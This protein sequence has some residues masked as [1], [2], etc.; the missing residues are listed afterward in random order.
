MTALDWY[1]VTLAGVATALYLERCRQ[2]KVYRDKYMGL[3]D[4]YADDMRMAYEAIVLPSS[5]F[6]DLNEALEMLR[7]ISVAEPV[8]MPVDPEKPES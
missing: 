3:L 8:E 6:Q 4:R 1:L 7:Q 5:G 2:V